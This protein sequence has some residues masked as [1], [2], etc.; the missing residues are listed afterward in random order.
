MKLRKYLRQ[1]SKKLLEWLKYK[2][3]KKYRDEVNSQLKQV[4]LEAYYR[5]QW[6]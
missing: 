5:K 6:D 1:K 3:S 4:K 2:F